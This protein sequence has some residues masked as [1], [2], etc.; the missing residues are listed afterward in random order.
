MP[1]KRTRRTAQDGASQGWAGA[2]GGAVR[3]QGRRHLPGCAPVPLAVLGTPPSATG[4]T[5]ASRACVWEARQCHLLSR[6]THSAVSSRGS[7]NALSSAASSDPLLLA[8]AC[9]NSAASALSFV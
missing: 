1:R 8:A 5:P 9:A 3:R 7:P 6:V 4:R 2:Q